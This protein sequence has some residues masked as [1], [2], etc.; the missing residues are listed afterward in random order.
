ML[1]DA[2]AD[3]NVVSSAVFALGHLHAGTA[4][5]FRPFATHESAD[6]RYAVATVLGGRT[7]PLSISLLLALMTD[8]AD[9]VRDW[10][11]FGIGSLGDVDTP[12][13]RDALAGRLDD[14]DEEVRAEAI[15]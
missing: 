12:E 11:T 15:F 2:N 3:A 7:D 14:R 1:R 8:A 5:D 6:V 10:A 13:V 9:I 4:D